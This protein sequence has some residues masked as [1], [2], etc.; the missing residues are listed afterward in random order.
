MIAFCGLD[1]TKCDAFIAT[2]N[3]DNKLREE[4][5]KKWKKEFNHPGL[6][7]EDINCDGCLSVDGILFK[8]CKFCKIRKCASGKE[9][10]NCVHCEDYSCIE[11]DEFHK[12]AKEAKVNLKN[13]RKSLV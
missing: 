13:I 1:C 4:T 9:I 2:K 5:A 10:E 12:H 11:L 7:S 3:N 6:R 8:H